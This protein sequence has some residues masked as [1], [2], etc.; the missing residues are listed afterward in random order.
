MVEHNRKVHW[1][2]GTSAMDVLASGSKT[3]KLGD[4][5]QI[6]G[7][8]PA[9]RKS[10]DGTP[11]AGVEELENASGTRSLIFTTTC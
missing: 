8:A 10:E 4:Q 11:A 5:P 2:P 1:V 6:L 3:P 7:Y 9:G